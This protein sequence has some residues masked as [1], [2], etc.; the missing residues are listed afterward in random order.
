MGR[1][2]TQVSCRPHMLQKR[3]FDAL[4]TE[5]LWQNQ[6]AGFK[7]GMVGRI[8]E[9]LESSMALSRAASASFAACARFSFASLSSFALRFFSR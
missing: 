7:F 8:P 9:G 2:A 6:D 1:G 4:R 5:Q 3:S